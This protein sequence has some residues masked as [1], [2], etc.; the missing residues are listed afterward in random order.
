MA[1][2]TLHFEEQAV[3]TAQRELRE[4]R[5]AFEEQLGIYKTAADELYQQTSQ[6][7]AKRRTW[8]ESN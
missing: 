2:D 7:M 1:T 5:E 6:Y 3:E 8:L 4:A